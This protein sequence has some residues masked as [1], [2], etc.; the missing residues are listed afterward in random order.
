MYVAILDR[1]ENAA[2]YDLARKGAAHAELLDQGMTSAVGVDQWPAHVAAAAQEACA[3]RKPQ[4]GFRAADG[5]RSVAKTE[6]VQR[7]LQLPSESVSGYSGSSLRS[8]RRVRIA[9]VSTNATVASFTHTA[10]GNTAPPIEACS[11]G[12]AFVPVME[13]RQVGDGDHATVCR[14][15]NRPSLGGVLSQREMRAAAAVVD[16]IGPDGPAEAR[17]VEYE[18][19]VQALAPN[20]PDHPFDVRPLPRRSRCG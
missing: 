17:L 15:L 20:G 5:T 18:D 1:I 2:R 3:Y 11:G 4:T 7:Q 6:P 9:T 10:R 13:S 19:M 12:A 14:R 8:E 16:E